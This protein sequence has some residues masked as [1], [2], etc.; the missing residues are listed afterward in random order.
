MVNLVVRHG[1]TLP[2]T[3]QKSHNLLERGVLR[4][5]LYHQRVR[6]R[7]SVRNPQ[8]TCDYDKNVTFLY[9]MLEASQ[10]EKAIR[11]CK[12]HPREVRTWIIRQN[13]WRLLPLH[14]AVIFQA[15]ETV[16]LTIIKAFPAA[17]SERDDQ[18]MTA[19]HL[20]FRH[21]QEEHLIEK[22]LNEYPNA[23]LTKDNQ[24]RLPIDCC[25]EEGHFTGR[26]LRLYLSA[27]SPQGQNIVQSDDVNHH[28]QRI[29]YEKRI[30]DMEKDH[31]KDVIAL[32]RLLQKQKDHQNR[33][34]E[35]FQFVLQNQKTLHDLCKQ[36]EEQ[37]Q[38]AQHIRDQLLRSL[39]QRD[40]DDPLVEISE[41]MKQ[42]STKI[43]LST[44]KIL[45]ESMFTQYHNTGREQREEWEN[46]RSE[47]QQDE[48]LEDNC[49]NISAITDNYY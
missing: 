18:G 9:E 22:I 21:Q 3:G 30:H 11:R 29:I 13:R 27:S 20:A 26:F 42:L 10:W 41:E 7:D 17:T 32:K 48:R 49:D 16:L 28:S 24:G 44:E 5:Q 23:A 1:P 37:L 36:Q 39:I 15:P 14:A 33:L 38:Q 45:N 12:N 40:D 19:L 4:T 6:N 8:L 35:K 47:M 43:M 25:A 2:Y 34:R 31:K 46:P